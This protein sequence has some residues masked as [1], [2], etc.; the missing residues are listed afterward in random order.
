MVSFR[1]THENS[2]IRSAESHLDAFKAAG[3]RAMVH[4]PYQT[5]DVSAHFT[6]VTAQ[7]WC[8]KVLLGILI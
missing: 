2:H 5:L 1:D 8:H 6:F 7:L 3:N 4:M